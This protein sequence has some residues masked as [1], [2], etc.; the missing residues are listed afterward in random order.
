METV[1]D[2][3]AVNVKYLCSQ[4][5]FLPNGTRKLS[6]YVVDTTPFISAMTNKDEVGF[7]FVAQIFELFLL[8][9]TRGRIFPR[10]I[11]LCLVSTD[12]DFIFF[13]SPV[14]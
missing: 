14:P 7:L 5:P 1:P 8:F 12:W 11:V 6:L 4:R 3:Y 9:L 13:H 2:G 10:A